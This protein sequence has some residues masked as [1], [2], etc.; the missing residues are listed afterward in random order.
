MVAQLYKYTKN[1][2]D[3][4]LKTSEILR[5]VNFISQKHC[6]KESTHTHLL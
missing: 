2:W 5:Y 6:K 3:H 4:I 1:H